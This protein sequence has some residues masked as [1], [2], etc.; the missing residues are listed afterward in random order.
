[1]RCGKS[2]PYF[3]IISSELISGARF[4][5]VFW[6]DVSNEDIAKS[7]FI[8]AA[9]MLGEK[10]ENIEEAKR[11]LSNAKERCL[12]I[13]D[14]ADDPHWDYD[15]Y[16]PSAMRGTIIMTSR[17]TE[18]K[19]FAKTESERV[20][21]SELDLQS[22]RRLLFTSSDIPGKL[23]EAKSKAANEVVQLLQSHTLALIQAGAYVRQQNCE[24][25]EYPVR[26]LKQQK[27]LL[28]SNPTTQK[29]SRY[30]NVYATFEASVEVLSMDAKELLSVLSELSYTFLPESIFAS[31]WEGTKQAN[32][33]T[34]TSE[35]GLGD[36]SSWETSQ[37]Y[38]VTD[39][40]GNNTGLD[41][42]DQWHVSQLPALIGAMESEWDDFHL[43]EAI[44]LLTSLSLITRTK[45]GDASGISM[46]PLVHA[47]A[48]L[49]QSEGDRTASWLAAG[50]IITLA[51]HSSS[52][53]KN[54][55]QHLQLHVQSWVDAKTKNKI[56]CCTQRT[57]VA[58]IW[59]CSWM[60][61]QM[62]DDSRLAILLKVLFRDNGLDVTQLQTSLVP[63]YHLLAQS[64][65]LNGNHKG[66]VALMKQV[67]KARQ[68]ALHEENASRLTAEH[69]L[70]VAYRQHG[71]TQDAVKLFEGVV[72]V[73]EKVL[74]ESNP[75][76]LASQHEL[77]GAY[78]ADGQVKK[79]VELLEAVV[80]ARETLAADHPS[81]LA[82]QHAL[83]GAYRADGQVKK[84]VE[85]L[86][87]VVKAQETLAA[88]HP[89]RLASQHA[90]AGAYRADGQVKKAVELLEAVVKARETLAADHPSR[91]ASQHELAGAYQADGQVKKA[92]ELLE[93]VV[94][95]KEKVMAA[96]HPDRL[97]SQHN[98]AIAYYADRQVKKAVELLEAVVTVKEKVMAA[99][100]PDR[101]A[102]V[103]ALTHLRA[104]LRSESKKGTWSSTSFR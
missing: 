29:R 22:C 103:E 61:V 55:G 72:A 74:P 10:V 15:M 2:R 48:R 42:L 47:W 57:T 59:S 45:Q 21:L 49:R 54:V 11:Q 90:L 99:D 5:A 23:W 86:E 80:K 25:E 73:Q 18:C 82:S 30:V 44:H 71:K 95:V 12:L 52:G 41:V 39:M 56:A 1:M 16:I 81:R 13:L 26:F 67:V 83:A 40:T 94:A 17:N 98:L 50:S 32:A 65:C 19:Q 96:D 35:I 58:L 63:L 27:R 14:N 43:N 64:H 85:L 60:L 31:A 92:V 28:E 8:V 104:E 9:A 100:H 89:D 6:V 34:S 91:L 51:A 101:L 97:A 76:R 84:A 7:N 33:R 24:L 87:A 102:S 62:R 4:W 93:A 36:I 53:R 37:P 38:S 66:A 70:A 68:N 69:L 3:L 20:P 88:D 75:S 46:H 78:R 77:A 79:A